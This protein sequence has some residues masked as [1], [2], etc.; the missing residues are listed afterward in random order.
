MLNAMNT[1]KHPQPYV[2]KARPSHTAVYCCLYICFGLLSTT[3][4]VPEYSDA[5][6]S[7]PQY[8]YT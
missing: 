2:A 3:K 6:V 5:Q 7:T 8:A 4:D 1:L